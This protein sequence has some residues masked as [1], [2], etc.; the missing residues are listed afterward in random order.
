MVSSIILIWATDTPKMAGP[1]NRR[2]LRTPASAKAITGR[3]RKPSRHRPAYCMASWVT[4]PAKHMKLKYI[5]VVQGT[6]SPETK[7]S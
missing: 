3:G 1:I 5:S 6:F 2:I 4:P 7:L